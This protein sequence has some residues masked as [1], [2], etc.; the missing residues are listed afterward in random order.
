MK[1]EIEAPPRPL[2]TG[3]IARIEVAMLLSLLAVL[4]GC[5]MAYQLNVASV[6]VLA[7]LAGGTAAV[8]GGGM[9]AAHLVY[10]RCERQSVR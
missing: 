3:V 10:K 6:Y 7:L 8:F 2:L 4:F 5:A 1:T 9:L